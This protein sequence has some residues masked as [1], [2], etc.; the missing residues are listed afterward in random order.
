VL[1]CTGGVKLRRQTILP[2][3]ASGLKIRGVQAGIEGSVLGFGPWAHG[4]DVARAVGLSVQ[5]GG[6]LAAEQRRDEAGRR[7]GGG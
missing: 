5:R 6:V 1:K 2:E 7:G 3:M 4:E